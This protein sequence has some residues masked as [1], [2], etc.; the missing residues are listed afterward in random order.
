MKI[1][2]LSYYLLVL[3]ISVLT[4]SLA[5]SQSADD[6]FFEKNV[7]PVLVERCQSCHGPD[8]QKSGLRVDSL[9]ALLKGGE[10]G[11]ALIPGKPSESL[12]CQV[13]DQ[14]EPYA[15]P[16]KEKLRKEQIQSIAAWV[17]AGARWPGQSVKAPAANHEVTPTGNQ[18]QLWSF[19]PPH[20]ANPPS[21]LDS[22]WCRSPVDR[23]LLAALE[24][25]GL[26]PAAMAARHLLIR[27]ATFDLTGL[28]PTPEEVDAFLRDNS[29]TAFSKV[30]D[31]LLASPA[32]GERW[33]RHWLDLA[34]YADSNGMDENMA[35]ANAFRYRDYVIRAF[36]TDKPYDQFLTEQ[37]AGDLLPTDDPDERARRITATGFLV[38]GPKMLAEDDP[39]KMEMDIVDEQLDTAGRAFLGM[40]FGCARCH[41]HKFDP[42]ST[43]DYYSMAGIF[44]STKTMANFRVVAMWNERPVPDKATLGVRATALQDLAARK[45]EI[46]SIIEKAW[47][48]LQGDHALHARALAAA[49]RV[50]YAPPIPGSNDSLLKQN[51]PP[52]TI[53][54]EAEK[55]QRGNLVRDYTTYGQGIGVVYNAGK[56]PNVAE[57]DFNIPKDGIYQVETRHAAAESRPVRLLIDGA[58]TREDSSSSVTGSWTPESQSWTV[59]GVVSLKAGKHVLKIERNGPVPHI[60]KIALALRPDLKTL[61]AD[62]ASVARESDLNP[63]LVNAWLA[64]LKKSKKLPTDSEVAT[65]ISQDSGPL[66]TIKDRESV[67]NES[68]K[69]AITA[70]RNAMAAAE[71]TLPPEPMAMAA[72]EGAVSNLKVHLRGNYLTLGADTARGFPKALSIATHAGIGASTSGRLELAQWMTNPNH[73]LTAR[74]MVNRLWHWHFGAGLVRT[75]DNFGRLGMK[76]VNQP[77]LDWLAVEFVRGGWSIKEM[78]RK[79]MNTSAYQMSC[80]HDSMSFQSD[81]DNTLF[82]R[83]NRRRLEAE[84]LRDG[85]ISLAGDLKATN[86]GSLL[87]VGNHKYVTSTASERFDPYHVDCRTVYLP[88]TRSSVYDFLQAFD[89]ADPSSSNGERVPTT[90]APQALALLNSRLVEEKT[91]S[92]ARKLVMRSD[93]DDAGRIT[94]IYKRAYSRQPKQH[95]LD[96]ATRFVQDLK[97]SFNGNPDEIST[98]AWQG[99][100]RAILAS[101]EFVHVD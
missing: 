8:K 55:F 63:A 66:S 22:S 59:A 38:I 6:T 20:Q 70:L 32:Y 56:I 27:R 77:L 93:L 3:S 18:Q 98:R 28:P 41:D 74:V 97:T 10:S 35:H 94:E 88:I 44:K 60:D 24:A 1:S 101:S 43:A 16:P 87:T 89:F 14:G 57:Y 52:G 84:A 96:R 5:R 7:R 64:W 61:P 78:H 45:K 54:L 80:A 19:Q 62:A 99:F 47:I 58:L 48:Q 81:P 92:W 83:M 46:D 76:P 51:I 13:I 40:T 86:G 26:K 50:L 33:A 82:W 65:I 95:E 21:V 100:C 53:L 30:I 67:L 15:M 42:I 90:V 4:S 23:F 72:S 34:R 69:I 68:S 71:K 17:K 29:P 79:I 49:K 36:N 25:K 12:L 9:A 73:P 39:R 11:P 85:I 31:R 91:L 75:P 2:S 37:I